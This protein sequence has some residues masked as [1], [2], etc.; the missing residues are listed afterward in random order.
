MNVFTMDLSAVTTAEL[1]ALASC[2]VTECL[3]QNPRGSLALH[4]HKPDYAHRARLEFTACSSPDV[5]AAL[6]EPIA[7]TCPADSAG[8]RLEIAGLGKLSE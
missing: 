6:R 1:S 4:W 7:G 8:S 3:R 5:L 2:I